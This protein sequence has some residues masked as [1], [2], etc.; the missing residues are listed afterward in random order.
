MLQNQSRKK[1]KLLTSH[2]KVNESNEITVSLD[3]NVKWANTDHINI[4]DEECNAHNCS[5]DDEV[6]GDE[7]NDDSGSNNRDKKNQAEEFGKSNEPTSNPSSTRV[8]SV[9]PNGAPARKHVFA[10]TLNSASPPFYPSSSSNQ[11]VPVTQKMDSGIII[12]TSSSYPFED[13]FFSNSSGVPRGK[14]VSRSNSQD[15]NYIDD[16][17]CPV[18]GK[19]SNQQSSG[20]PPQRSSN[21]QVVRVSQQAHANQRLTSRASS[22]DSSENGELDSPTGLNKSKTALVGKGKLNQVE[23]SRL[24][25]IM[26]PLGV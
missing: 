20:F 15:R 4:D 8:S 12:K 10:S 2:E 19:S 14:N 13:N 5:N 24:F 3:N 22:T 23:G 7:E 9:Q 26:G 18:V 6:N 21:N 11:D 1:A 16:S 25:S 17:I